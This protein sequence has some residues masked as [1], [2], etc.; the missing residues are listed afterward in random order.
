MATFNSENTLAIAL[1]AIKNQTIQRGKIEILVLDG[2]STD[3]TIKIAKKF[4]CKIIDNPRTEPSY[5]K[6]LG[7]IKAQGKYVMFLDSDEELLNKNSL[8]NRISTLESNK[9]VHAIIGSGFVNPKGYPFISDYINNVSEP[10]SHFI[11]SECLDTRFFIP[12]LKKKFAQILETQTAIIFDVSKTKKFSLL[13]FTGGGGMVDKD[14]FIR[15]YPQLLK[16]FSHLN[17]MFYYL[18]NTKSALFAVSKIDPIAHYS[19]VTIQQYMNK[20][21]WRIKNNIFHKETTGAAGFLGRAKLQNPYIKIKMYLFIPYAFSIVLPLIDSI[22]LVFSRR[23]YLFLVHVPLTIYTAT[24][25]VYYYFLN[26]FG[27]KPA[28]K[29]YG[30]NKIVEENIP[31]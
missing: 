8:K 27:I 11:Y 17:H 13:E 21:K 30:E 1:K 28:F 26:I 24:L 14:F 5:G 10:F 18:T 15:K 19:S 31:I 20:I 29:S 3:R 9:Y 16:S 25:I 23:N 12:N 7:F 22:G 6:Y 2:G 4:N